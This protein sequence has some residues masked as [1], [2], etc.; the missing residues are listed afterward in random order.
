MIPE[1]GVECRRDSK[2][3]SLG[4]CRL[5][6][7]LKRIRKGLYQFRWIWNPMQ[8][9]FSTF[10]LSE[11]RNIAEA[12]FR[13]I[14]AISS[15]FRYYLLIMAIPFT[16]I[17]LLVGFSSGSGGS[18]IVTKPSLLLSV[19][20]V[21]ISVVGFLVLLYVVSLR[22][23]VILYARVVNAIRKHF[24]DS[25]TAIDAGLMERVLPQ[26]PFTPKYFETSYFLP[27]VLTFGVLNSVYL[28]GGFILTAVS[29]VDVSLETVSP[30]ALLPV[31]ALVLFHAVVYWAYASFRETAYLRGRG[32]GVDID[33]VLNKHRDHFSNLLQ[34]IAQKTVF[35]DAMT[36]LPLHEDP[37]L[38][39]TRDD[40]KLVFNTPKYWTNMPVLENAA[41]Y[42]GRLRNSLGARI[43][44]FTSRPWPSEG[45][46]K[47]R[48]ELSKW[49]DAALKVLQ[50]TKTPSYTAVIQ[51]WK[52]A[53]QKTLDELRLRY[54]VGWLA[55]RPIDIIT[56][57]WLTKNGFE[58]DELVIE[59]G[60][61]D[62]SDPQ[63]ECLN[64]IYI[65]RE[66][67]LRFFIEDDAEKAC[68]LA[69]ICDVVF[70][71]RHPY[72][73]GSALPGNVIR[74]SS[75]DEIYRW[76]RKLS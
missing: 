43:Y 1:A 14:S 8:T 5:L 52:W 47:N 34:E 59:R 55:L 73:R 74:V 46:R 56:K 69:Y 53:T 66:K 48:V 64:R 54:G 45:V 12:H 36:S 32:I 9:E 41:E 63:G 35:P 39:V 37:L 10:L 75:W 16:L 71:L 25:G 62:V 65:S 72:N 42:L 57:Y 50:D 18:S 60:S 51:R 28:V 29:L 58:Y 68:K 26:T 76:I 17:G 61:E 49:K 24:Y 38:G 4:P 11:Y 3:P 21:V 44:V 23:D 13:T 20:F 27:V 2:T 15:F 31:V 6:Q 33:G 40:E 22:M 7:G 70:L 19:V 67:G 30:A